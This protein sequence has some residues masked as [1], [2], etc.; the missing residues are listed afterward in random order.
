MPGQILC[1]NICSCAR[2]INSRKVMC[3][4]GGIRRW[5]VGVRTHCSDDYLWL[6][7]AVSLYVHTTGDTGVLDEA[8]HFVQG[9]PVKA[10]GGFVLRS[11]RH[12]GRK[13]QASTNTVS[14]P[15]SMASPLV[16]MVCRLSVPVTGM[17]VWI[18]WVR[19]VKGKAYG[20]VFSS[21]KYW[22]VFSPIAQTRGDMTFFER[23]QEEAKVLRRN[24]EQHGWDGQWYLAVP[25]LTT[26]RRWG[27]SNQ[28]GMSDR[29]NCPKLVGPFR[30]WRSRALTIGHG[31]VE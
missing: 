11:S 25:I 26:V 8:I 16:N 4:T 14:A 1:A 6:P 17:T 21:M 19:R 27:S 5:I 15:L 29:F 7:L 28:S 3:S 24:I 9:R 18:W 10:E 31:I 2:P 30:S 23:F 13:R 12:I 22:S 20:W